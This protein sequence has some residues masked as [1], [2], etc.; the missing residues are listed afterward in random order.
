MELRDRLEFCRKC[1][2]RKIMD[3]GPIN[4]ALTNTLPS[5]EGSCEHFTKDETEPEKNLDNH[6]ILKPDEIKEKAHPKIYEKII[7]DQDF[8]KAIFYGL[9]AG[10]IGAFLWALISV[11]IKLQFGIMAIGVGVLVG[12]TIKYF[13][14]GIS[15]KYSI[16]GSTISLFGCLLGNFLMVVAFASKE[17][18]ITFFQL[19]NHV[20]LSK[21]PQIMWSTAH[22]MDFVFYAITIYEGF[23]FST[24]KFTERSLWEYSQINKN[25]C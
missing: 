12:F 5:F 6:F 1:K 7:N 4:C 21:I 20:P 17:M 11:L 14:K 2:N 22:P 24:I 9:F 15:L 3:V 19:F 8:T 18:N 10:I 23:R 16:L 25:V 13:G